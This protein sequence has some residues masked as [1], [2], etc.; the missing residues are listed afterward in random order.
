VTTAA[1]LGVN[2]STLGLPAA[3][4]ACRARLAAGEGGYACFVNVHTLTESTRDPALHG[5]LA[6]ATFCFADG[7]PLVWLARALGTPIAGRVCGPDFMAALLAAEPDRVH[8]FLGGVPG[9][10]EA[11]A[12]RFGVPAAI[13][14]PPM[15]AFSPADAAEDWQALLARCPDRRPPGI[16]W[17]GLGAP[18]QERW[19]HEVSR[20][21][22]GCLLLGV[23]AAFDFLSGATPRA[24]EVLQRAGLEWAYRL[25]TEPR[26]LWRRYLT[27]NTR[28]AALAA[29]AILSPRSR[30]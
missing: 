10:A 23:G 11:I 25:A 18:K 3:L 5:A 29:R 13:H 14:S 6:G 9:R 27:T 15:R 4:A 12:A 7:M 22:P 8:G 30:D 20:R 28:F 2:V 21:A 19:L 26:R 24:P 17:V 1:L 16:V